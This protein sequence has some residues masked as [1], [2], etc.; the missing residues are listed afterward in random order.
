MKTLRLLVLINSV[1]FGGVFTSHTKEPVYRMDFTNDLDVNRLLR[2]ASVFRQSVWGTPGETY[3]IAEGQNVAE[4]QY[5]F[6][7]KLP[8]EGLL[9]IRSNL[10]TLMAKNGTVTRLTFNSGIMP[11]EEAH[12]AALEISTMMNLQTDR[13]SEWYKKANTPKGVTSCLLMTRSYPR[14]AVEIRSSMNRLY[15]Y[16]LTALVTWN[17]LLG[18]PGKVPAPFPE[19]M[20]IS[21]DPPSGKIYDPAEMW[22]HPKENARQMEEWMKR[23][24][25][26]ADRVRQEL[27]EQKRKYPPKPSSSA[28]LPPPPAAPPV[29]TPSHFWKWLFAILLALAAGGILLWRWLRR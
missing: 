27:E 28:A 19:P 23:N 4:N 6:E 25:G 11:L 22:G 3:Y 7:V 2:E 1:L 12:Q 8:K 21:L 16:M 17:D 15:P 10:A 24:P 26:E 20:T 5:V 13:I 18:G 29:P 14:L 9:K